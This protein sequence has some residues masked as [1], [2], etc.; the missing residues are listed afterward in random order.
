MAESNQMPII[1]VC[2]DTSNASAVTLR[3][4]CLKA[5]RLGF[6]VQILSVLESSHKNLL[7]GSHVM[8]LEKRKSLEI[9]LQKLID[10]VAAETGIVPVVSIREGDVSTEIMREIK[11]IPNCMTL[12]FGKSNKLHSDNTVLPRIAQKIGTKIRIPILIV[13]E[14]LDENLM[15][16]ML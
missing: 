10:S 4:A 6:A 1:L 15:K 13:P 5:K 16:L 11:S 8:G 3:Y 14:N 2:V 9:Y 7:F 12:I